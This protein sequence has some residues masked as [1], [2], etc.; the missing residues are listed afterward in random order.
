MSLCPLW[1][2]RLNDVIA[3]ILGRARR[4]DPPVSPARD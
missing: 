3:G 2:S 1:D 4:G